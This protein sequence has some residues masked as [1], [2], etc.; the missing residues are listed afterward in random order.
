MDSGEGHGCVEEGRG[1]KG[2]GDEHLADIALHAGVASC[3]LRGIVEEVMEE[4]F[5]VGRE[6]GEG[7]NMAD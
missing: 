3:D 7:I 2:H 4:G 5:L 1:L 6:G